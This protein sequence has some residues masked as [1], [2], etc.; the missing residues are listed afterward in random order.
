[1]AEFASG[2]PLDSYAAGIDGEFAAIGSTIWLGHNQIGRA[3]V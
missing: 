1:M 2:T 3:H